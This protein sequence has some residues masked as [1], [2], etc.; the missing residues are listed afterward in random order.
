V[1]PEPTTPSADQKSV[2][3][4]ATDQACPSLRQQSDEGNP[5]YAVF[6]FAGT[7]QREVCTAARAAGGG[8]YGKWLDYSTDPAYVIPC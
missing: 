7:T 8:A 6:K 2:V 3:T 1:S 4:L 5:I